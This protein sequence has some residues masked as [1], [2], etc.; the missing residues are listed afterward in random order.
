MTADQVC[1]PLQERIRAQ[2]CPDSHP[3]ASSTLRVE[4]PPLV[5]CPWATPI[6]AACRLRPPSKPVALSTDTVTLTATATLITSSIISIIQ[7]HRP[8]PTCPFQSPPALWSV[9]LLCPHRVLVSAA[10]TV[11]AAPQPTTMTR[12]AA[13]KDL[14]IFRFT[15]TSTNNNNS[16]NDIFNSQSGFQNAKRQKN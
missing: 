11:V 16:N 15:S 12:Y 4:G 14:P 2:P 3:A 1:R 13:P 10:A 8:Q 5:T 6:P 9:P 7:H